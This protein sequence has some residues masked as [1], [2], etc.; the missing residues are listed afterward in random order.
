[1]PWFILDRAGLSLPAEQLPERPDDANADS[2]DFFTPW[3]KDDEHLHVENGT[4]QGIHTRA[5]TVE[6]ARQQLLFFLGHEA[7]LLEKCGGRE[8]ILIPQAEEALR[9]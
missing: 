3:Y 7:T 8:D 5:A 2:G 9:N 4:I 1:M 6:E